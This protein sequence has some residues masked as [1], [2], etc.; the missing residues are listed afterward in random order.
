[1][2][3]PVTTGPPAGWPSRIR[4]VVGGLW[5]GGRDPGGGG[6]AGFDQRRGDAGDARAGGGADRPT[7]APAGLGVRAPVG[8]VVERVTGTSGVSLPAREDGASRSGIDRR[9]PLRPTERPGACLDVKEPG[10]T[11]TDRAA[12]CTPGREGARR[13]RSAAR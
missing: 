10:T 6:L 7:A 11:P 8:P 3:S 2:T 9:P 4:A 1:M 5:P 12:G 13:P